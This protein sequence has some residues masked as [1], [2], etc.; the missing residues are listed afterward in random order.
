MFIGV[1]KK[2]DHVIS[3]TQDLIAV[4]R[5]NGQVDLI[6]IIKD[7]MGIRVDIPGIVTI[8]YGQNTVSVEHEDIVV[9][10]F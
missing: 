6:P 9:T 10:T 5:K 7:E 4:E 2:G 3:V 8:G 1:L